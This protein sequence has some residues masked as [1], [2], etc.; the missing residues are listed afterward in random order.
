[1]DNIALPKKPTKFGQY[2]RIGTVAS[3][4]GACSAIAINAFDIGSNLYDRGQKNGAQTAVVETEIDN[5]AER[6]AKLERDNNQ[7]SKNAA[8][9]ERIDSTIRKLEATTGSADVTRIINQNAYL[10]KRITE[11]ED[12]LSQLPTSISGVSDETLTSMVN[13]AIK[14]LEPKLQDNFSTKKIEISELSKN[15]PKI[16]NE[17]S[18]EVGDFIISFD[19][20]IHEDGD[21]I[22]YYN[23][24]NKSSNTSKYCISS[25]AIIISNTG[26]DLN[27]GLR[28]GLGDLK[29]EQKACKDIP[30]GVTFR[31]FNAVDTYKYDKTVQYYKYICGKDCVFEFRDLQ[32]S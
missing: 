22:F 1:M 32:P 17:K 26:S 8:A 13:N 24:L 2:I 23:V 14:K 28:A 7:G 11:L 25:D 30:P 6:T 21:F 3:V 20:F 18:I 4:V 29:W 10:E 31:G 15:A 19:E 27:N 16:N 9:I 12:K 5:L